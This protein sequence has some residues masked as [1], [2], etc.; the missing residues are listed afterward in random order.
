MSDGDE[1]RNP[2]VD[3]RDLGSAW[4]L[5][6]VLFFSVFAFFMV[7]QVFSNHPQANILVDDFLESYG[8]STGSKTGPGYLTETRFD[9]QTASSARYFVLPYANRAGTD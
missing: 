8:N 4:I 7:Q 5:V 3:G 1:R 9:N 6:G 2:S